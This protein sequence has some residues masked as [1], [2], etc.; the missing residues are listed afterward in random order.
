M[1]P[2]V[3]VHR[4]RDHDWGGGGEIKRG[5]KVAG[6][7]LREVSQNIGGGGSNEESVNRLRD[8]NVFDGGVDVGN[9]VFGGR[10]HSGD[11]FFAGERSEG[12]RADKLLSGAGHDDLHANT[13]VLQQANDFGRLVS[14]DSAR[15]SESDFHCYLPAPKGAFASHGCGIAKAMP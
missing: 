15:H 6:D 3:H 13:A 8:R 1:V 10:E 2:H 7:A 12:E 11:H 4:G 5:E 14:R 9:V